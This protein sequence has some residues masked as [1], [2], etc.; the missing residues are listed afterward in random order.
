MKYNAKYDRWFSKEG[1]NLLIKENKNLY[2]REYLYYKKFGH[3]RW[4]EE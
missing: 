2:M 4:E 1:Y 3:C